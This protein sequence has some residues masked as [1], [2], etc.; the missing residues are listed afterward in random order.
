[1]AD[2][3]LSENALKPASMTLKLLKI[4]WRSSFKS[5]VKFLLDSRLTEIEIN[6][7]EKGVHTALKSIVKL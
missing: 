5:R 4:S 1:M 7:I 6:T 3:H 2:G